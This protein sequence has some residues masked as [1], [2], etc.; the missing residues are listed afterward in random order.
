MELTKEELIKMFDEQI[1][2]TFDEKIIRYFD[3]QQK[4]MIVNK[5][6]LPVDKMLDTEGKLKEIIKQLITGE[7]KKDVLFG[8]NASGGYAIPTELAEEL[9]AYTLPNSI[10]LQKAKAIKNKSGKMDFVGVNWQYANIT[11]GFWGGIKCEFTDEATAPTET[12]PGWYKVSLS[13]E[14][15]R[16]YVEISRLWLTGNAINGQ[17]SIANLLAQALGFYIDYYC[18]N[19]DG[20]GHYPLGVLNAT[21]LITHTRKTANQVAYEDL[22]GMYSKFYLQ[23]NGNPVWIINQSTLNYIAQMTGGTNQLIFV[24]PNTGQVN[25]IYGIPVH[26]TW[27][28]PVLGSTGDV[29]LADLAYYG[30]LLQEEMRI[31]ASADYKFPTDMIAMKAIMNVDGAPLCDNKI[32]YATST[33]ASPFVALA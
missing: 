11:N 7:V 1:N 2:K 5:P 12:Q 13:A 24:N 18:I 26:I 33:Y 22:A 6:Q 29:I 17:A 32:A 19:G 30:V 3:E 14:A 28:N 21:S 25:S 9:I 10:F 8:T 31:E 20:S 23:G 16:A 27:A 4:K 15:L